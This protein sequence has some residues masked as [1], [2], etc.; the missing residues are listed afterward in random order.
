MCAYISVYRYTVLYPEG[1]IIKC[2][3]VAIFELNIF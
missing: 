3:F 1:D 2:H